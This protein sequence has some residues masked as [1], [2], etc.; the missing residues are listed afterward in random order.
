M[1]LLLLIAICLAFIALGQLTVV[2]ATA[3]GLTAAKVPTLFDRVVRSYLVRLLII[4][5]V[6]L[7]VLAP[8]AFAADNTVTVPWGDWLASVLDWSSTILAAIALW[9]LRRLPRSI[10]DALQTLRVEQLLSR[11]V[12]YGLSAVEG[13]VAGK[14]LDLHVTSQV[15]QAAADYAVSNAPALVAWI[16]PDTLKAK[17]LARLE[18]APE[19][20]AAAIG[21][22]T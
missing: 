20:T 8:A 11:A 18:V 2:P 9:L 12:G 10:Y 19:V 3:G 6:A 13:A 21:A 5:A 17:I 7:L 22:K 1:L 15:L 14:T 4:S 16:G